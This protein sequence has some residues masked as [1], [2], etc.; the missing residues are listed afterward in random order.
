MALKQQFE[1]IRNELDEYCRHI[2]RNPHEVTLVSVSKTVG[3]DVIAEAV[4]AGI[5][6]FG[7]NRPDSLLEKQQAYPDVRW[8][9]IGNIQSRRIKDIVSAA[10]LIHSVYKANHLPLIDAAAC[11][12]GKVQDILLEVNISGE[13]AKGGI[14]PNEIE[15]FIEQAQ[16]LS[17]VRIKGFMT[18]APQGDKAIAQQCFADLAQLKKEVEEKNSGTEKLQDFN[19]LSMGMS[20]DWR[21]AVSE[22]ATIVRIGRAIF[23]E[24]FWR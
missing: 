11:A 18:M 24:S 17:H 16:D 10:D 1:L 19:E 2:G 15:G 23:D 4:T 8:H 12:Q 21:E 20:E 9:F 14:S 5:R 7:E 6:E 22:G 13:Q 3:L